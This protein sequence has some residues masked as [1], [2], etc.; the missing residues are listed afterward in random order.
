MEGLVMTAY[1][2]FLARECDSSWCYA[3]AGTQLLE[4]NRNK[5][6]ANMQVRSNSCLNVSIMDRV[7]RDFPP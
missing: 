5:T 2:D 1:T 3:H 6:V 4:Y 7:T